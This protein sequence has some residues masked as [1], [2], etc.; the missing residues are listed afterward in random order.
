MKNLILVPFLFLCTNLNA[1]GFWSAKEVYEE[2]SFTADEVRKLVVETSGGNIKVEGG[3]RE[4]RIQMF[5]LRNGTYLEAGEDLGDWEYSIE[6]RG[7]TLHARAKNNH[8]RGWTKSNKLSVS[9][10]VEVPENIA[11]DLKTSGGNVELRDLSG[12]QIFRTSGGNLTIQN[13]RGRMDGRTSGGNITANDI[14]GEVVLETSG[15]NINLTAADG[16]IEI[17]TSGGSLTLNEVSGTIEGRTSGGNINAKILDIEKSLELHTSGGSVAISIP[18]DDGYDLNLSGSYVDTDLKNFSGT[19]KKDYVRGSMNGGG[20][21]IK[22]STSGGTV[23]LNY[24]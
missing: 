22:A 6:M 24:Y 21:R 14:R 1:Q 16:S 17:A 7:S 9:F 3:A 10:V 8:S 15:G 13:L 2:K 19:S 5:V 11:S 23:R 12:D 20:K 4:A 18:S